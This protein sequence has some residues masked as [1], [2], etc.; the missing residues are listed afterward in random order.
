MENMDI[1]AVFSSIY[2]EYTITFYD[3]EKTIAKTICHYGDPVAFPD[4]FRKGYDL[5]WSKTPEKVEGS[6]DIYAR[7]T[8]SNPVGREAGS[9]RGTYRIVNPSV[10]MERWS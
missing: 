5:G 1:Y 10:K 7:W 2:N 6:C 9:G 4:I 3:E 8:F